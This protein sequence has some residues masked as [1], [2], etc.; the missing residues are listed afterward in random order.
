MSDGFVRVNKSRP[1]PVCKKTDWCLVAKDGSAAICPRVPS[2][3]PLGESGFLHKLAE[4]TRM[5]I[6]KCFEP[7]EVR[8]D[9][10]SIMAKYWDAMTESERDRLAGDLGVHSHAL[11]AL[12]VG[13]ADQYLEGTYAFPMRDPSGNIIGIRLRNATGSKW[14]VAGSRAGLFFGT[15][16]RGVPIYVCE[17]PTD[18]AALI[19]LG[20]SAIGKPSCSSGNDMIKAM[21]DYY[22]PPLVVIV[23]DVDGKEHCDFCET[24]FCPTCRPG[25]YGAERTARVLSALGV[26]IKVIEP[27]EAK[28]IRQWYKQGGTKRGLQRI[29]EC[30]DLWTPRL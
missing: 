12:S 23:A 15:I 13:K 10:V 18:T 2:N 1:C 21:I 29:V 22:R 17:G 11:V 8:I 9:P 19:S 5:H 25:Q 20:K 3:K 24:D 14:A 26:S 30:T 4:S 28:D 16:E 27:V 7:K 6:P